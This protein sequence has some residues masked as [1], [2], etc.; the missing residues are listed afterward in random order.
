MTTFFDILIIIMILLGAYILR[1]NGFIKNLVTFV[2]I[3]IA[4]IVSSIVSTILFNLLYKVLPFLNLIG[5]AQG[6][7]IINV[8]FWR[9]VFFF[10][11]FAL[12]IVVVRKI[13]YETNVYKKLEPDASTSGLINTALAFVVGL[14]AMVVI[15]F[16]MTIILMFP[17]FGLKSF[18]NSTVQNILV[19]NTPILYS[20]N[21]NYYENEKYAINRL[22]KDDNTKEGYVDVGNDILRNMRKTGF[23]DSSIIKYLNSNNKLVGT[24]EED[25]RISNDTSEDTSSN[26]SSDNNSNSNKKG[27]SKDAKSNSNTDLSDDDLDDLTDDD[28][29]E[30]N[31]LD[32]NPNG[33]LIDD[34]GYDSDID[35]LFNDF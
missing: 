25:I 30:D 27:Q 13:L 3:Y 28:L 35:K 34:T 32:D 15:T 21:S 18:S 23:L 6:I 16:D 33:D 12:I 2:L 20:I 7:K 4:S 26:S 10:I 29:S 8:F 14:A 11:I 31:V 1:V 24:R 5:R 17:M 22:S 19:K 9:G